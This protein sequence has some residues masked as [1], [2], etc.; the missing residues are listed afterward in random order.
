MDDIGNTATD[1][2]DGRKKISQTNGIAMGAMCEV[3]IVTTK[4]SGTMK[5]M[6]VGGSKLVTPGAWVLCHY[7]PDDCH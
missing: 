5:V 6:V 4:P 3:T 1:A 2:P 7:H